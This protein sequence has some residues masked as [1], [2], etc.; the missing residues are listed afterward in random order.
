MTERCECVSRALALVQGSELW[1]YSSGSEVA[2]Q[3][4]SSLA[5]PRSVQRAGC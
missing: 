3:V 4:P 1:K 5:F 2:Y